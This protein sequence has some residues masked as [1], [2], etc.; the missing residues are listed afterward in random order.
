MKK[1]IL[2]VDDEKHMLSLLRKA[3]KSDENEI[4]EASNGEEAFEFIRKHDVDLVL[5]DISMPKMQGTELFFKIKKMNPF[6]QIIIITAYPSLQNIAN[7]LEG[8]ASDFIIKPFEIEDLQR[9]VDETVKRIERWRNL[10]L[11]WLE[12]KKNMRA[13]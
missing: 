13:K 3:L 1:K 5:T 11:Q 4:Y 2:V 12:Y 8:G 6:I 9:I 10:R 7:M